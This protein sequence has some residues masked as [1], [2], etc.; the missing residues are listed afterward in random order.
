MRRIETVFLAG[1]DPWFPDAEKLT[2][3]RV[4]L[5]AEA[6]FNA[7]TP[8]LGQ[9]RDENARNEVMARALYAEN[10]AKL[11]GADAL[12]ANFS[13]W[14]GPHADPA[15][16]F[17]AGAAAAQ[18]KPVFAYLNVEDAEEAELRGRIEGWTGAAP[19]DAGVWRDGDAGEVEDY[20]LPETCMLWAEARRFFVLVVDDPFT[21]LNGL[22]LC[23]DALRLYND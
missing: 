10:L 11:R 15:T 13:P 2:A 17:F 21:D 5:C 23:L 14:R 4:A 3:Q 7:V 12:I 1:P 16:A 22:K 6:G 20:L 19:D 8:D 18:S 9:G